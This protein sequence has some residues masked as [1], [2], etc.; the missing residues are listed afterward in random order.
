MRTFVDCPRSIRRAIFAVLG[1]EE[2][3]NPDFIPEMVGGVYGHPIVGDLWADLSFKA[4][5]NNGWDCLEDSFYI[6]EEEP[7]DKTGDCEL[8]G[9]CVLY[10]DDVSVLASAAKIRPWCQEGEQDQTEL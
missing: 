9:T 8:A 4:F 1:W 10:V 6:F 2:A 5:T 7:D 3:L